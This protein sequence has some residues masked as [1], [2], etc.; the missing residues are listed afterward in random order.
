MHEQNRSAQHECAYAA[1]VDRPGHVL[2]FAR[3][4]EAQLHL[5]VRGDAFARLRVGD[6]ASADAATGRDHLAIN[7]LLS[8]E[9]HTTGSIRTSEP[10][11]E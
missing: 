1:T 10:T 2:D 4:E 6:D 5:H 7:A 9:S 11:T 8:G 3:P